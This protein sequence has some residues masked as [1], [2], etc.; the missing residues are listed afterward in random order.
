MMLVG[1]VILRF[2]WLMA[3]SI[4]IVGARYSGS[5]SFWVGD[6]GVLWL[7]LLEESIT[8]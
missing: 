2:N 5:A 8:S 6:D 4:G 7:L 1:W 3:S